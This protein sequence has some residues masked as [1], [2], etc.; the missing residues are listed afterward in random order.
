MQD[1]I[2][3]SVKAKGFEDLYDVTQSG[4]IIAKKTNHVKVF[5]GDPYNF[6]NVHLYKDGE[7]ELFKTYDL[8]KEVFGGEFADS[9]YK[10]KR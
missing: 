5:N 4:R 6:A 2:R 7:R 3:K 10:G 1:E 8:W 9:E